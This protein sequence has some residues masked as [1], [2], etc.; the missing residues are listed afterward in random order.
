MCVAYTLNYGPWL[1]A[2]WLAQQRELMQEYLV[3]HPDAR[4]VWR[5]F[6]DLDGDHA[7]PANAEEMA[8]AF[9]KGIVQNDPTRI[10]GPHVRMMQWFMIIKWVK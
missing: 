10:K 1:C 4:F 8:T 7:M 9:D 5:M 6:A 3:R 2:A